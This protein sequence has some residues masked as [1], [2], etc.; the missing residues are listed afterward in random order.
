MALKARKSAVENSNLEAVVDPQDPPSP[1]GHTTGNFPVSHDTDVALGKSASLQILLGVDPKVAWANVA[2]GG[3]SKQNG[4]PAGKIAD[5]VVPVDL[6]HLLDCQ[7]L[8]KMELREKYRG[9]ATCHRKMLEREKKLGRTVHPQFRKFPDFLAVVGPKPVP[10][11]TLDRINNHD[12][13]YAPGKV[14]WADKKTQN[15]NKSDNLTFHDAATGEHYTASRLAKLQ[16]VKPSTI[17]KRQERGW[18]HAEIIAGERLPPPAPPTVVEPIK[19]PVPIA[20]AS[21]LEG[22]W[23]QAMEAAYPGECS[24]LTSAERGMLKTFASICSEAYLASRAGEILALMIKY[25]T[26]YVIKT[27]CDHAAFNTPSRPTISF[28]IK[29][30]RPALTLWLGANGLEM[31]NGVPQPKARKP[32][33]V[34]EPQPTAPPPPPPPEPKKPTWAE[35]MAHAADDDDEL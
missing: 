14:R 32:V 30:P 26:D 23:V 8:S 20:H 24:V 4:P 25:W 17:R 18:T 31:K 1:D 22:A 34:P 2:L 28:L 5:C 6:P 27:R 7:T 9:E 11:A 13:E 35:L 15:N 19:V 16:N 10:K 21:Q 33:S 3:T 12:P 29:Y